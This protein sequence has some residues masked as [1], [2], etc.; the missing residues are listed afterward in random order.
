[1]RYLWYFMSYIS[2]TFSNSVAQTLF[3]VNL[4]DFWDIKWYTEMLWPLKHDYPK[5][6]TLGKNCVW[7]YFF[8]YLRH[9]ISYF[10]MTFSNFAAH[11][12]FFAI[13]KYFSNKKSIFKKFWP[14]EQDYPKNYTLGKN[15]VS[16]YFRQYLQNL[17]SYISATFSNLVAQ[18]FFFA[19]SKD[20]SVKKLFLKKLWLLE[21]E[22]PKNPLWGK[23]GYPYIFVNI[24]KIWAATSVRPLEFL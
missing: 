8:P 4:K 17:I 23:I 6:V 2:E 24:S 22:Y 19:N 1:M 9:F 16:V 21:H 13:S 12:F 15:S 7:V 18:T 14:S 11:T 10:N 3:F 5:N 20:F